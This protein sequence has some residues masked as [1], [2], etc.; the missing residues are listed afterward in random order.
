MYNRSSIYWASPHGTEILIRARNECREQRVRTQINT[1]VML[2]VLVTSALRLSTYTND[3]T[4]PCSLW[5]IIRYTY[6]GIYT[7]KHTHKKNDSNQINQVWKT[8]TARVLSIHREKTTVWHRATYEKCIQCRRSG[9]R[10]G[11]SWMNS[12]IV[13]DAC[14]FHSW[15]KE[16]EGEEIDFCSVRIRFARSLG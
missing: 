6:A 16:G 10:S 9:M 1:I 12:H 13:C 7:H 14:F 8:V 4:L 3:Q 5:P 11:F 15:E 2:Q